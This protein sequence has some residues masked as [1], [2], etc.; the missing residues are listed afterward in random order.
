MEKRGLPAG[1]SL[2]FIGT[3]M[4]SGVLVHPVLLFIGHAMAPGNLARGAGL[5]AEARQRSVTERFCPVAPPL[6]VPLVDDQHP[7]AG[8]GDCDRE[9]ADE[10]ILRFEF[11]RTDTKVVLVRSFPRHN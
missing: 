2:L 5:V 9:V 6:G 7:F 3:S 1:C 8:L 4:R 11:F 10:W